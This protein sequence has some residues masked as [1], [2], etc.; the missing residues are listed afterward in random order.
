LGEFTFEQVPER[1]AVNDLV[2]AD[3]AHVLGKSEMIAGPGDLNQWP[4]FFY[5]QLP[6]V[7]MNTD[8]APE[9][10]SESGKLDFQTPC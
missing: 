8:D 10:F 4:T 5:D 7:N 9:L 6:G 2:A 3:I 1:Y